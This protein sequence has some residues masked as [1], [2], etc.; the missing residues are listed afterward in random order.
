MYY[1]VK[2][3][4]LFYLLYFIVKAAICTTGS[5]FISSSYLVLKSGSCEII[6]AHFFLIVIV[7]PHDIEV[8]ARNEVL[9]CFKIVFGVLS[10][11]TKVGRMC[12]ECGFS[13]WRKAQSGPAVPIPHG[14]PRIDGWLLLT[15]HLASWALS[16]RK[17]MWQIKNGTP[18]F[19][20][21]NSIDLHNNLKNEFPRIRQGQ[22]CFS[23]CYDARSICLIRRGGI[24]RGCD[25]L[26]KQAVIG[27]TSRCILVNTFWFAA[28]NESHFPLNN[29]IKTHL[30]TP[31]QTKSA[32]ASLLH[33]CKLLPRVTIIYSWGGPASLGGFTCARE[34]L[35]AS[36]VER[37]Q[38][39]GV[40]RRQARWR[41]NRGGVQFQDLDD[42]ALWLTPSEKHLSAR[43]ISIS[44]P[45]Q[46]VT[47]LATAEHWLEPEY[48][49]SR[50]NV[51]HEPVM[52]SPARGRRRR[53]RKN[54]NLHFS[55]SF[56]FHLLSSA[57]TVSQQRTL[58][59][60]LPLVPFVDRYLFIF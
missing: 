29:K 30:W 43:N 56:A 6:C 27:L 2:C 48:W 16:H 44:C 38:S 40:T 4:F 41:N 22:T 52:A 60:K 26:E 19:M 37:C 21:V 25:R 59:G 55:H 42:G 57:A 39:P 34:G 36:I 54:N 23:V 13:W 18:A 45:S 32:D 15:W 49:R 50:I 3:Y 33:G 58:Q 7:V 35:F 24:G 46:P 53:R 47:S 31:W 10:R 1:V 5:N 28:V 12:W 8:R 9:S 11:C 20:S 51:A 17:P 14:P